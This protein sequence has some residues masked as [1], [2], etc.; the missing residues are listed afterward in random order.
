MQI[1]TDPT[2][3]LIAMLSAAY[4]SPA[5]AQRRQYDPVMVDGSVG[6]S[7]VLLGENAMIQSVRPQKAAPTIAPA[8]IASPSAGP[9]IPI[10]AMIFKSSP[11]PKVCRGSV[12]LD[13]NIPKPPPTAPACYNTP[14]VAS[15]AVFAANMEDGCQA[16]IFAEPNCF[17]FVNLA[18][19]TPEKRPVG[20][21]F[22]SVEITCGVVS[23]QPAPLNLPGLKLPAQG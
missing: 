22:R 1:H 9:V 17:S 13:I 5:C 7:E 10:S 2:T 16:R 19:F 3:L 18:V 12:M 23:V 4:I 8:A 21:S 11:G 20:G 14:E 6:Q 15:C